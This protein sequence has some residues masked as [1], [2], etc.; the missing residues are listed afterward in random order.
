[1]NNFKSL[2]TIIK[3]VVANKTTNHAS[4]R[5]C[6]TIRSMY[7]QRAKIE[8]H[9][10]DQL[11]VGTYFT[12]HFEMSPKA[13]LLYS[14]LPKDTDPTHAEKSAILQ[15]QLFA[16]EK[17]TKARES[18]NKEDIRTAEDL[19]K[20]IKY[21]ADKMNLKKEHSYIDDN[22]S[23]I[24]NAYKNFPEIPI[25]DTDD[26]VEVLKKKTTTSPPYERNP[27]PTRDLDLDSKEFLI[28]RNLKAQRKL[29]IID[30]D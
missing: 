12:K 16:L 9:E 14:K 26:E 23:N 6:T 29:K 15:D 22:L 20:K 1:M 27:E 2:E 11:A 30:T 5:I 4:N 28:R 10:G 17:Q 8:K 21:F 7:E 25:A 24:K 13:Q 3:E 18:S 19:V